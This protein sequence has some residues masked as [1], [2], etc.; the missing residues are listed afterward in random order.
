VPVP[1][2]N[3][4]PGLLAL[5]HAKGVKVMASIGG[6][7]MC[8]HFPAT[9]ADPTM[10]ARFVNDCRRLMTI[11]FDGIDF[12]WEYP[13]PFAGMN[14]TGSSADYTNFVLLIQQVRAAIGTNKEISL[15]LSATP[16]KLNGFDWSALVAAVDS[17]NLMTYD[18]EGGWA[19]TAGHNAPLY[20]YPNEEGGP[21]AASLCVADL[22]ARGVPRSKIA[23][24][25]PFYG[26]GVVCSNAAALNGGTVLTSTFVQP[27]GPIIS[28]ADFVNWPTSVWAGTPNYSYLRTNTPGWTRFWDPI[29]QVPYLTS[30]V[31]FLSYDD[32]HSV[33]LKAQ[34]ARN[35]NLGGVII[36]NAFGDLIPGTL[37]TTSGDSGKLPFSPVN[38]A[39]LVNVLNSVLAGDPVPADGTEGPAAAVPVLNGG[40][41]AGAGAFV[42]NFSGP[43]GKGYR[44]LT[45][46]NLSLPT[47][48]WSLL[49]SGMFGF[50]LLN[51]TNRAATNVQQFYRV[52]S[53]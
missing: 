42:L 52:V 7:S 37:R 40:W 18:F 19:S 51:Y 8:K 39:P 11:G 1:N 16:A 13:G 5:A 45:S 36:W 34:Y 41:P 9:A 24:G 30:G 22:I 3:G 47:T 15:C 29:A 46:T 25:V 20:P 27:D 31:Y 50:S 33:G 14:F 38:G 12:D 2:V 32:S 53:P 44:L 28:C 23:M 26:R 17:V 43:N 10:R 6:W 49:T 35:Q 4:A 21:Q 48:N